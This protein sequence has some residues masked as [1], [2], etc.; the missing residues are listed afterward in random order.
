MNKIWLGSPHMGVVDIGTLIMPLLKI[1]LRLK[2][3][4]SMASKRIY[5][6]MEGLRMLLLL[7]EVLVLFTWL[8]IFLV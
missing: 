8:Q 3:Q 5:S 6:L 1:G 7:V 2:V 4:T